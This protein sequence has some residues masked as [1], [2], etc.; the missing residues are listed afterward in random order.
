MDV[1]STVSAAKGFTDVY[2]F[3]ESMVTSGKCATQY[4]A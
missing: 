3:Q 4:K 2:T 1:G